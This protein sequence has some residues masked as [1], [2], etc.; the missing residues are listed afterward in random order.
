MGK[1]NTS[2]IDKKHFWLYYRGNVVFFTF[3]H[4]LTS[5]GDVS[6]SVNATAIA[7]GGS[8]AK[9]FDCGNGTYTNGASVSFNFTF[10]NAPKVV[11][12]LNVNPGSTDLYSCNAYNIT[13]TGFTLAAHNINTTFSQ[14][15][16]VVSTQMNWIAVG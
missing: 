15:Y 10:T 11:I 6:G 4:P 5:N 8:S 7:T 16:A 3:T 14:I 13:T 1:L 2:F 12:L 9:Q